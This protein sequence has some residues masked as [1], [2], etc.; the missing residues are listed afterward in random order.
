MS[1]NGALNVKRYWRVKMSD[2]METVERIILEHIKKNNTSPRALAIKIGMS[3][4]WLSGL[5]K[6]G[7]FYLAVP[8]LCELIPEL[9]PMKAAALD[10]SKDVQILKA[11]AIGEKNRS[12]KKKNADASTGIFFVDPADFPEMWKP[13]VTLPARIWV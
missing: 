12:H 11:K 3:A 2:Q 4:N 7:N 10:I 5:M 8:R 1:A 13:V 6:A 9:E